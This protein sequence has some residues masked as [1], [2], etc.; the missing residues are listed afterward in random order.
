MINK[1]K[2]PLLDEMASKE[3][4]PLFPIA[5]KKHNEQFLTWDFDF[6]HMTPESENTFILGFCGGVGY[7]SDMFAQ[8][9]NQLRDKIKELEG[10]KAPTLERQ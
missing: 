9:I 3:E 5:R 2:T 10:I 4:N 6:L 7:A 8:Q 1:L